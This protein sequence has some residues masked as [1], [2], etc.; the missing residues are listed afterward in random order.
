MVGISHK[1][2][3]RRSVMPRQGSLPVPPRARLQ[4]G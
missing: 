2:G 4:G 1:S 3:P